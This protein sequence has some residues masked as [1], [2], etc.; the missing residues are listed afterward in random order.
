LVGEYANWFG[1]RAARIARAVLKGRVLMF[2][3][4]QSRRR[5]F[6]LAAA[7]CAA[8]MLAAAPSANAALGGSPM[9][10][11][12]G[13]N[14]TTS[15]ASATSATSGS[16]ATATMRNAITTGASAATSASAS[17]AAPY[18]LR[19]T[20]LATG[21]VV[22]EYVNTNGEVFAACWN[23][24]AMPSL[25]DIFGSDYYQQYVEGARAAQAARGGIAHGPA[26]VEQGGLVVRAGGH[27][28]H[29][30]GCGYLP[31]LM[32]PGVTGDDI[33]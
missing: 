28:L 12:Q 25:T 31:A 26:T 4:N 21:T 7:F 10:T 17:G 33:R 22:R 32:P 11:P 5:V 8:G 3:S 18:T 27:M 9:T 13:A 1:L 23:G 24:P 19:S 2:E 15:S 14:V 30:V 29:Y 16:S 6:A 20:T